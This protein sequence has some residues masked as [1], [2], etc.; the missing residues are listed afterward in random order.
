M[1]LAVLNR[2][3]AGVP[4]QNV[5]LADLG[6]APAQRVVVRDVWAGTTSGAVAGAFVT[7]AIDTHETLLLKITP[8]SE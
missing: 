1:A 2:G 5:S 8:L 7:R 3:S 6:F 4:G